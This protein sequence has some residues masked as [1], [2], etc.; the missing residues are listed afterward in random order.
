MCEALDSTIGTLL[1]TSKNVGVITPYDAEWASLGL[2]IATRTD[3]H[4]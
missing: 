2:A 1:V 4:C 3:Q